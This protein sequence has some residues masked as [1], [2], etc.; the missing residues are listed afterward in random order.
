MDARRIISIVYSTFK[1]EDVR[2][3]MLTGSCATMTQNEDSDIDVVLLSR[4]ACRQT[5]AEVIENDIRIHY[6]IFPKNKIYDLIFEDIFK[7]KFR[8]TLV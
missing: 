3:I 2:G 1:K 6:I 8:S 7:P 4:Y 5:T